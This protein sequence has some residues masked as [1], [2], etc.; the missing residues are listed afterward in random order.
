MRRT[1]QD[2]ARV[3]AVDGLVQRS[4]CGH[5][6]E[7]MTERYSSVAQAEVQAALGKVVS[8]AGYRGLLGSERGGKK[9]SGGKDHFDSNHPSRVP[10]A[11]AGYSS[12]F[13]ERDIGFEPTTFSL[14]SKDGRLSKGWRR[15]VASCKSARGLRP[16]ERRVPRNSAR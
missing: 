6:T 9:Q 8:L 3:A 12:A 10:V 11:S 7:E 1:F 15:V 5:L 4:I 2:L 14:G 16:I 13:R